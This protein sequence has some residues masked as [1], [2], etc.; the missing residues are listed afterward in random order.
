MLFMV[1]FVFVFIQNIVTS[2][3]KLHPR[4]KS[5]SLHVMSHTFNVGQWHNARY[6][7]RPGKFTMCTP[8][9]PWL[10]VAQLEKES[11]A[12]LS[13]PQKFF[14]VII[15]CPL[16]CSVDH[17]AM[18]HNIRSVVLVRIWVLHKFI[19]FMLV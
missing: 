9:P 7:M 18:T 2:T 11:K 1:V 16:P 17:T 19:W 8:A 13:Q 4:I 12:E 5:A 6:H 14:N 3:F 15:L 10:L